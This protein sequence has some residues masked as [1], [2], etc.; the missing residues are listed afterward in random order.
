MP[1]TKPKAN[2]PAI[3]AAMLAATPI[4]IGAS[5]AQLPAATD[6]EAAAGLVHDPAAQRYSDDHSGGRCQ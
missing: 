1:P 2:R 6:R 3:N 5:T 4:R